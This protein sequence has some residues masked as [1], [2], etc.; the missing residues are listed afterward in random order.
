M[1]FA[2]FSLFPKGSRNCAFS[3]S[4]ACVVLGITSKMGP[5]GTLT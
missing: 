3:R 2:K 4:L 5:I 1:L